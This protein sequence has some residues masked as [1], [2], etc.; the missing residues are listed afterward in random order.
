MKTIL[1]SP[2]TFNLAT[3]GR[4]IALARA[5]AGDF[6]CHFSSYGGAFETLI[7][8]EGFP[9]TRLEPRLTPE[10]IERLYAIDQARWIGPSHSVGYVRQMVRSELA[11]YQSLQPAAVVTGMNPSTC[12]SCPTAQIPLIWVVQSG[13]AM[14]TAAQ[15][16]PHSLLLSLMANLGLREALLSAWKEEAGQAL[17]FPSLALEDA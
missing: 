7:E 5:I 9:L 6:H 11:L 10:R 16:A 8:K 15:A 14:N 4:T 12:I 17:T 13:I 3:T 2:I 1:F